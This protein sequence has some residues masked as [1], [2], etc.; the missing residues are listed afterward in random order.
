MLIALG[1]ASK[2]APLILE[3][4]NLKNKFDAIVDGNVVSNAKPDPEVFLKCALFLNIAP[5]NCLVF[6]DA[7]AGIEAARNAGM[8]VIGVGSPEVLSNANLYIDGFS[9]MNYPLLTDWD[10]KNYSLL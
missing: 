7:Q 2:N 1:S 3:R 4:I 6:E 5:A 9:H 10:A 8:R